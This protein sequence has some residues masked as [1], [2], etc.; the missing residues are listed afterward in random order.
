MPNLNNSVIPDFKNSSQKF[1]QNN[2]NSTMNNNNQLD[3]TL[4]NKRG[5]AKETNSLTRK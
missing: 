2:Y 1:N 5:A 4:N 3:S